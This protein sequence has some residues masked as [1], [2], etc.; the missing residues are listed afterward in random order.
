MASS[1]ISS[2]APP[3]HVVGSV[4]PGVKCII[5]FFLFAAAGLL[6]TLL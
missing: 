1:F 4:L 5:A 3:L 2:F 6:A